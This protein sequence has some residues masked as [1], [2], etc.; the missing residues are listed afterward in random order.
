MAYLCGMISS[1]KTQITDY[2]NRQSKKYVQNRYIEQ[3]S[4]MNVS[5]FFG[6]LGPTAISY[7]T[8]FYENKVFDK[9]TII[10]SPEYS[11]EN[12]LLQLADI[13]DFVYRKNIMPSFCNISSLN[14]KGAQYT[15]L[16]FCNSLEGKS[17]QNAKTITKFFNI[18]QSAYVNVEKIF[19]FTISCM[20]LDRGKDYITPY[21]NI[22]L[23]IFLSNL[24][25]CKVSVK[26]ISKLKMGATY[27]TIDVSSM[28]YDIQVYYYYDKFPMLNINIKS[29]Y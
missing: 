19:C 13:E 2:S 15:D 20:I 23:C 17:G 3:C 29:F 4:N 21:V 8:P 6:F 25:G 1:N 22:D 5:T 27:Y 11:K 14:Y 7:L 26:G 24:L 28:K 12:Y 18:Q 10:Q 16:D 9:N